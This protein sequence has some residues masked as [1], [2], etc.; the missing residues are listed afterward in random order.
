MFNLG[1]RVGP[2]VAGARVAGS[3]EG[4]P[5]GAKKLIKAEFFGRARSD[6]RKKVSSSES[7]GFA[8]ADLILNIE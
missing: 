8:Q 4:D 5:A 3:C 2:S 7:E 6:C 1:P